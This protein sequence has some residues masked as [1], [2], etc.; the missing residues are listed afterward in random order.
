MGYKR[1]FWKDHVTQYENR[2]TEINNA[3]GT[4]THEPVEGEII[5]Q[6]TPQNEPNFNNIEEGIFAAS[7][8][9]SE[10]IR[11]LH[12]HG[13]TLRKLI[14][15][16]GQTVLTNSLE[17]PFNNSVKTINLA[18]MRDTT[19]YTV[20]IDIIAANGAVGRFVITDKQ[21]NG[22]KIAY[23]GGA[24]SVTVRYSIKGGVY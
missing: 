9:G 23:T 3:D 19:D 13:Q 8:L 11:T 5:Q 21:L 10:A 24:S 1:T 22:F 14:G 2:Y 16:V 15:E 6:G 17:Y 4:I 7:E 20:D 12:H 18:T